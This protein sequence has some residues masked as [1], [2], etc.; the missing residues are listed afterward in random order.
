MYISRV[1]L[2]NWRNFRDV[3]VQL[4]RRSF[5]V[6]QNASGKSNFLDVFRFLG[7]IAKSGGGLQQAIVERGGFIK[8]RSLFA[9]STPSIG[10]DIE[11]KR[12]I[13][14]KMPTWRYSLGL[15]IE[16]RGNRRL[17]ITYEEVIKDGKLLLERPN[18]QD[19]E[20]E[21]L[22]TQTHLEQINSNKDFREIADFFESIYYLH[23]VPQVIK[24]PDAFRGKEIKG[25]PFGHYFLNK[26]MKA[27]KNIRI[28]R[29]KKN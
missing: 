29:L 27:K 11:I 12:N 3:D 17:L 2:K 22:L 5:L 8:V 9:R 15:E 23:L 19:N 14:D 10:I 21:E 18:E 6:G 7:D 4:H 20:D 25:D 13:E 24:N 1:Q 28:S 26:L 16:Q